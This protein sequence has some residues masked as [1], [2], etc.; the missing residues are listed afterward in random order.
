[1]K[2]IRIGNDIRLAVDLRQYLGE[3]YLYEREVYDKQQNEFENIDANPFVNKQYE[4]YYPNQYDNVSD[5][6]ITIK[7]EGTPIS[8][9]SVKAILVNTSQ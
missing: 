6:S 7:P 2:K 4:V 8:I 3:H 5:E 1:M 9:R